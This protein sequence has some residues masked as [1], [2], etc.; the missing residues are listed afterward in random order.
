MEEQLFI[1]LNLAKENNTNICVAIMDIDNFKTI[2]DKYGHI[3]GD[4][5]LKKVANTLSKY[6]CNDNNFVV[7]FGG[8]EFL[9]VSDNKDFLTFSQELNLIKQ[10]IQMSQPV[11]E[12][13]L[14][15][16]I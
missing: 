3:V 12:Q 6:F 1:R 14:I 2:N 15:L 4:I 11:S 9:V 10:Q 7:R 13:L 5:V 8:D 16:I